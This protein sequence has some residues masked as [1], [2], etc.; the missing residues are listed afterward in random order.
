MRETRRCLR[1]EDVKVRVILG[2]IL[3]VIGGVWIFQGSG[4][5][6]GSF[7]TGQSLWLWIGIVCAFAG[8][9]LLVSALLG[10]LD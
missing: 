4:L 7:M 10:R 6:K 2:V 5:L 9:L 8:V 3:L 1:L